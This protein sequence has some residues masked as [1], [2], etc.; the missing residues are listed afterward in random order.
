[1]PALCWATVYSYYSTVSPQLG[2]RPLVVVQVVGGL[3]AT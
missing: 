3:Y 2:T 1:M